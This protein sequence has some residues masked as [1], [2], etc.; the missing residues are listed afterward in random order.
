P[1][2]DAVGPAVAED[3]PQARTADR[4]E[5]TPARVEAHRAGVEVTDGLLLQRFVDNGEQLAFTA[6]VRRHER[7]VLG[8]C[9]RV[10]GD[11]H[12]ARDAVQQTFLV[13]ARK[14]GVLDRQ[15]PLAGWLWTGA[16]RPALRLR[17]GTP[18]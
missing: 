5:L 1:K 9:E 16:S 7:F 14:A 17:A 18:R 13:L 10:L 12:A 11:P 2:A 3:V 6:L 8:I 4:T 15:G